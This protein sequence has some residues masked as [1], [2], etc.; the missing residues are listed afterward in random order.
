MIEYT[1]K[2]RKKKKEINRNGIIKQNLD[3]SKEK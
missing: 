3:K 2:E 1:R